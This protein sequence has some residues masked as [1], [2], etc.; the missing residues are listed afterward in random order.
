MSMKPKI[1]SFFGRLRQY[2]VSGASNDA[3]KFGYKITNWY[4][5]HNLP[6][7]PINPKSPEI[8]GQ[9]ATTSVENILQGLKGGADIGENGLKDKN[10]VSISFL[11]P[12]HITNTTLMEIAGVDKYKELIT[13]LWFQ[14]GSY[15]KL[16]I[17]TAQKMGLFDKVVY[18]DEC[19]LVRGEEGLY[20]ANL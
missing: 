5:Q 11:T 16:V 19:I 2:A 1:Q 9:V 20:S 4:I 7:I 8:L 3:S 18:Q 14:P 6:V 10:G 13:G 15:D 17:D 12:P